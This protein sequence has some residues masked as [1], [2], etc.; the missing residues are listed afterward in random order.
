MADSPSSKR[1]Y[2][3]SS[4]IQYGF[5]SVIRSGKENPQCVVCLKTLS[6]GAMK[7]SLLRRHFNGCHPH[8]ADKDIDYFKRLESSVKKSRL[9][10]TGQFQ[11]QNEAA[12]RASYLVAFRIARAKKPHTIGEN[13]ILPCCKDIVRI[14]VNEEAEKKLSRI[15]LSN[16]TVKRRITAI[17]DDIKNQVI[18]ELRGAHLFSLRLDDSTDVAHCSQ[19]LVFV[20]YVKDGDFKDEF[21]FC[22]PLSSTTKG[23]DIFLQVSRFLEREGLSWSNVAGCTTDGAPSMLGCHSGFRAKTQQV[24]PSIQHLHCMIHRYALACKT[25]PPELKCVL[26]DA[27]KIVNHIKSCALNSRIL[28]LLCQEFKT[29]HEVLLFHTEVRWLSRGNM[30]ARLQSMRDVLIE[31]FNRSNG[32]KSDFFLSK[33]NYR[34]WSL[35][36]SYLSDIFSRLNTLNKSLQGQHETVIDFVDKVSAFIKK[37]ELWESAVASQNFHMFDDFSQALEGNDD[38]RDHMS[39]LVKA[40]LSALRSEFLSYFPDMEKLNAKWMRNPFNVDP[41]NIPEKLQEFVD[42]VNDSWA[43]DA[44]ESHS[45]VQ[46]WCE[47]SQRYPNVSCEPISTLLV[48]P[49]TY[50]CEQGFST[51]FNLKDKCRSQLC[52]E[53]D[54]RVALSKTAPCFDRLVAKVQAQPSH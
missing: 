30:L 48:F 8:L 12:I 22:E 33:L 32:K 35:K 37:L 7:P 17:S 53:S 54:L 21:L 18:G 24:N 2:Y 10:S 29:E 50:L 51:L 41:A 40:H 42:L 36:L 6:E 46:F 11:Q 20:R 1:R 45:L 4:Y 39:S 19:L 23:E 34:C 13:L 38:V 26:D 25:L 31:F 15:S 28:K 43:R 16:D 49:S 14:M 52:V 27:V 9:D 3:Q 5:T 44:Y 47:M